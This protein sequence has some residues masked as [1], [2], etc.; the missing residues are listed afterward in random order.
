MSATSS[1]SYGMGGSSKSDA[2]AGKTLM[3]A[4]VEDNLNSPEKN[5]NT[6]VSGYLMEVRFN[7][8]IFTLMRCYVITSTLDTQSVTVELTSAPIYFI[9]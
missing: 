3:V 2:S 8:L 5:K 6:N 7:R 9:I 4:T 1:G